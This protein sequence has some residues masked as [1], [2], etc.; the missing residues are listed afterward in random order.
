MEEEKKGTEEI[1]EDTT[2]QE[3]P[4]AD[5]TQVLDNKKPEDEG[6]KI[7]VD[8]KDYDTIQKKAADFDGMVEK[9]RLAK[10][11]KKD[12]PKETKP[13]GTIDVDAIM[14]RAEEAA[15][16]TADARIQE[17]NK[18]TY[19]D[20]LEIAFKQFTNKHG[21]ANT[22]E[23]IAKISENFKR[24]SALTTD[25][26]VA[27]L[28]KAALENFPQEYTKSLE[29]K[30]RSKV[31]AEDSNIQAGGTGGTGTPPKEVVNTSAATAEDI[32]IAEKFF[33][34]DVERYLKT[35]AKRAT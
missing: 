17:V 2:K 21:W 20:N 22:D 34:G 10:L 28:D 33:R 27:Q 25:E 26:L 29:D 19:E 14:Q 8:V 35:K 1:V 9:Q 16:R 23:H 6:T 18:S 15:K 5:N 32:R 24:N 31:L 12:A 4:A 13:E 7:S 30:V 3:V 11:A